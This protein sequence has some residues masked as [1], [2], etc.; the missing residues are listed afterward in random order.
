MRARYQRIPYIIQE[1][2]ILRCPSAKIA[3]ETPYFSPAAEAVELLEG[4]PLGTICIA[5][6]NRLGFEA[7]LSV[8]AIILLD[9]SA[10]KFKPGETQHEFNPDQVACGMVR[11][12]R[13]S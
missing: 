10:W 1:P 8:R 3:T 2:F 7:A 13:D 4:A 11:K 5:E 12:S 9:P 6:C